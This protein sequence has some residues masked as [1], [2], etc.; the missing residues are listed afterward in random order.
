MADKAK[1]KINQ[2]NINN[3]SNYGSSF[4][5]IVFT[6]LIGIFVFNENYHGK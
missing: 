2:K 3:A 1:E 6:I 5:S 4:C